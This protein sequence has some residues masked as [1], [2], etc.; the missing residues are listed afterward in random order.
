MRLYAVDI[1]PGIDVHKVY[2]LLEA[3][4]SDDVWGF[5]EGNYVPAA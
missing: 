5:D 2:A 4:E 3:G 1:P